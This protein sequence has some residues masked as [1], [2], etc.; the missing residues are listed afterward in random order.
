MGDVLD[1]VIRFP[2]TAILLVH[3]LVMTALRRRYRNKPL[4]E[5]DGEFV[6][7]NPNRQFSFAFF[8]RPKVKRRDIVKIE[9]TDERL[10]LFNQNDNATD[11]WVKKRYLEQA[12]QEAKQIFPSA[13]FMPVRG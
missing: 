5:N 8:W 2:F 10:T 12:L 1:T 11:V 13:A 7:I 3:V 4:F 9:Y 6:R